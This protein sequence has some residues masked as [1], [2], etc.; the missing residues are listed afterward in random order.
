MWRSLPSAEGGGQTAI[1]AVRRSYEA[2]RHPGR[3][4][5]TYLRVLLVGIDPGFGALRRPR[6]RHSWRT[7]RGHPRSGTDRPGR[8]PRR[9]RYCK[10][11]EAPSAEPVSRWQ[12]SGPTGVDRSALSDPAAVAQPER[13]LPPGSSYRSS[14]ECSTACTLTVL[15]LM[16]SSLAISP[17]TAQPPEPQHLPLPLGQLRQPRS[18]PQPPRPAPAYGDRPSPAAP[19]LRPRPATARRRARP[20]TDEPPAG[21]HP[22]STA[23]SH[24]TSPPR[25][26]AIEP[27]PHANGFPPYRAVS[28]TS[29]ATAR[30]DPECRGSGPAR[31]RGAPDPSPARRRRPCPASNGS[32]GHSARTLSI[33]AAMPVRRRRGRHRPLPV[34]RP[35]APRRRPAPGSPEPTTVGVPR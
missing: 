30:A 31:P 5:G 20:H 13:R 32:H 9:R 29:A 12:P 21:A 26:T 22:P 8:R 27:W 17:S 25:H 19:A 18:H 14:E 24:W 15:S 3:R 6:D 4:T 7:C 1:H 35:E 33:I 23:T 28:T 2:H 10:P 34:R 16:N 11:L